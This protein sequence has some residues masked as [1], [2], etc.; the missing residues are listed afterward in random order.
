MT[1]WSQLMNL[2]NTTP[3]NVYED[4]LKKMAVNQCCTIIYTVI[5]A[6]L[7]PCSFLHL[8]RVTGLKIFASTWCNTMWFFFLQSGT[9]GPPKGVM[10]SHD[11]VTWISHSLA[12]YLNIRD[13]KDTFLSYL[14]LSHVA[15]Q[16]SHA[17]RVLLEF[18]VYQSCFRFRL[19]IFIYRCPLE[20]QSTLL[21]PMP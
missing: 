9:T 1:Q 10:L 14:P 4:R 2:G 6:P 21:N 5:F 17:F 11:N 13:G 12:T 19:R 18:S 8:L 7:P 16:V 15:A 20:E 3:D